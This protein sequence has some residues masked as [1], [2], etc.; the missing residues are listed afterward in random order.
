[1]ARTKIDEMVVG[2]NMG[3]GTL[4]ALISSIENQ[5][6]DPT[7]LALLTRPI[8]AEN[9]A[10]I[11][12][13][14]ID[15]DWRFPVSEI[16]KIA[17][18]EFRT[19]NYLDKA[20]FSGHARHMYWSGALTKLGIPFTRFWREPSMS[21]RN[22]RAGIPLEVHERLDGKVVEYPLLMDQWVVVHCVTNDA[23]LLKEGDTIDT[24]ALSSLVLVES[25]FLNFDA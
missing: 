19:S 5:K 21:P 16:R 14:V 11:A 2:M 12:K 9:L 23:R 17:E 24:Q 1:M 15:G 7:V 13:A 8:F 20:D 3:A 22:P 10:K 18:H 25:K 4:Q 6:G